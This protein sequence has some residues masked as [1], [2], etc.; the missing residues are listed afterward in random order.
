MQRDIL[1]FITLLLLC[2]SCSTWVR[3]AAHN[4]VNYSVHAIYTH[5]V[6]A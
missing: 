3:L 4:G 5:K 1:L 6:D 2:K